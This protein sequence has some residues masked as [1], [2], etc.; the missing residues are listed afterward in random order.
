MKRKKLL[1]LILALAMTVCLLAG[2]GQTAEEEVQPTAEPT[3]EPSVAPEETGETESATPEY[4]TILLEK[5]DAY[6]AEDV[7]MTVDGTEI[8]WGMYFYLLSAGLQEYARYLGALPENYSLELSDGS[9]MEDYFNVMALQQAK[10]YGA[11]MARA[12]EAGI[13]PSEEDEAEIAA[14]WEEMAAAYGGEDA[15]RAMSFMTGDVYRDLMRFDTGLLGLQTQM[16]GAEGELVP[17]EDILSWGEENS[18]VS[19]KHILYLYEDEEGNP[20]DDAGK[21]EILEKA[22]AVQEELAA[23]ADDSQQLEAR[24]DEIMNAESG[25]KGG[26]MLFPDGYTFTT[27]QMVQSFEDAAFALGDYELSDVVESEYGC[28]ILLRL[29]M[30]ADNQTMNQSSTTGGYYTLRHLAVSQMLTDAI[31]QWIAEAQIVWA[32]DYQDFSVVTLF[33]E[34]AGPAED[35]AEEPSADTTAEDTAE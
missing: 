16:F 28:H 6:P 30:R 21:A 35:A 2:C 26:L 10:L 31:D 23:L 32:E 13:V 14:S 3:A 7:V 34:N 20:L 24:F 27:G 9:T 15:V 22:R 8:N 25:D 17:D 19:I 33:P 18:Y 29:P 4:M 1:A 12:G 5:M 11:V